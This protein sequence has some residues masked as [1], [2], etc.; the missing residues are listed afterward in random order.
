[1]RKLRRSM[2]DL[3]QHFQIENA[4]AQAKDASLKADRQESQVG[5]VQDQVERLTL[6]C[7]AMWELL[8]DHSGLT[9]SEL[10]KKIVEI[11]GR[12]GSVDGQL[13]AEIISC[14]HCGHKTNT[15]KSRCVFCGKGVKAMHAFKS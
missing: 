1:M 11:D 7:Q 15:R 8:R 2:W 13:A 14:P 9:E 10:R 3:L 4:R 12:D 6:A 5:S